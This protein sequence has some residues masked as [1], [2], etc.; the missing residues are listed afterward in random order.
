M[1]GP[2]VSFVV[3]VCDGERW[4]AETLDSID[5]QRDG[6]PF[7]VIAVDDASRDGSP[8]ILAGRAAAGR[9]RML[10]ASARGAAAAMNQG[11]REAKH[12]IVCIVDQD[13][14]LRPGWLAALLPAL[15]EPAVGAA[16]GRFVTDPA[17]PAVA[18]VAAMDL[19]QR[20]AAM[21]G[22]R[23]THV[24]TGNSAYR[25]SALREAG[26]FDE[27]LGY[28]YDNDTS[29]RLS[30]A[31]YE[32]RYCPGATSVHRWRETLGGYLRQQY[33]Q[34]YG[35]LDVVA[36][37]PRR[38][39]GDTVS[40]ALMML[41][42]PLMLAAL[43]AIALVPPAAAAGLA[44]RY[45]LW[46]GGLIV[47]GLAAERLAAG[48]RAALRHRDPAGLLFAPLHLLRDAAWALATVVWAARRLL[49]RARHPSHS[50]GRR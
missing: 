39:S 30:A 32:L 5:I 46:C 42:A 21:P 11:I 1:T 23:T 37:H 17:A 40:P 14:M 12:P 34:G 7:E 13:V 15:D 38:A 50:M 2:G 44:W 49:G 6:R 10:T 28:G 18:R 9:V 22:G 8:G 20:Y 43:G 26:L 35:R 33:G 25:A 24:C 29:Y 19:E 48:V 45:P 4:L 16:Q 47:C 3:P 31:G 36:K 41:H 27:S